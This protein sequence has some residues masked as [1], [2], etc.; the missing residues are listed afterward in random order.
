MNSLKNLFYVFFLSLGG[1]F[2]TIRNDIP[3]S[4]IAQKS[5]ER[6]RQAWHYFQDAQRCLKENK[7]EK[8]FKQFKIICTR[9][10]ETSIAPE[11]FFYWGQELRKL[12]KI[13]QAFEKFKFVTKNHVNYRNYGQV[14]EE[15]FDLASRIM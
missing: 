8:A 11:A 9:Y 13:E 14:V 7:V 2:H 3:P 4:Q 1:C 10:L 5:P 6:D 15:V 12:G